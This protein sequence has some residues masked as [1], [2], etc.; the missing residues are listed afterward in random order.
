[1]ERIW[2]H[3]CSIY[4]FYFSNRMCVCVFFF[5]LVQCVL[6]CWL[7]VSLFFLLLSLRC[8]DDMFNLFQIKRSR[9]LYI[10]KILDRSWIDCG[11]HKLAIQFSNCHRHLY[12][13]VQITLL[14]IN[15]NAHRLNN[16]IYTHLS[17][18]S[19]LIAVQAY[20]VKWYS[21]K[22]QPTNY[23][24]KL[25]LMI[26]KKANDFFPLFSQSVKND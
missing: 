13:C 12:I 5:V 14:I 16:N 4:Y 19:K 9:M 8:A 11:M 26:K 1:M 15:P 6:L 25:I 2:I 22:S 10:H 24:L 7:F 18:L 21:N 17:R 3:C 23:K 20:D